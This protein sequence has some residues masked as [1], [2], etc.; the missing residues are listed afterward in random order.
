MDALVTQHWPMYPFRVRTPAPLPRVLGFVFSLSIC[1]AT[2]VGL[3]VKA[4]LVPRVL[5]GYVPVLIHFRE[6]GCN[7]LAI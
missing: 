5:P 6:P 1:A 7:V 3:V 2:Q 4:A